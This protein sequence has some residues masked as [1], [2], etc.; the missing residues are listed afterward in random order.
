MP[1]ELALRWQAARRCAS[2]GVQL[3]GVPRSGR[4]ARSIQGLM[5]ADS[6]PWGVVYLSVPLDDWN[7]PAE[8]GALGLLLE[9][10]VD[11]APVVPQ[12]ALDLLVGALDRASA[13]ALVLGPGADTEEGFQ[14]A[15]ALAERARLPV[16]IAPS[17]PRAPFPTRHRCYQGQ[18]PSAAGAV[19][20]I[21]AQYDVVVCFGAPLFRYHAPSDQDFLQPG[22]SVYAVTDDPDEAARAPF[23]RICVGDPSDALVR[24]AATAAA[25]DRPWPPA[26]TLPEADTSG[27]PF[28]AEAILDAI[29][30]GKS[31]D[32]VIALEWTSADMVRDRLT[33]TRPKSL[34][35]PAAGGL[36]WGL[37]AAIGL[38]LGCPER[39]VVALIGD[40]AMQYTTSGLWSAVRYRVPVTFVVCTNTTYRAL[41]AFSE[42]LHVPEGDYLDISGL[43][44]LDIARGYGLDVHRA[45]SLED[46]T[47]YVRKG[48]TATGPRLVEILQ[49]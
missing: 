4:T 48:M 38:R 45:E 17:P 5:L 1:E 13:P 21:L 32:T 41:Q 27:P 39:P 43:G 6:A 24:V 34:F 25:S 19:A 42:I 9:R 11:G 7:E 23:G 10:A 35:Y 18:L 3:A 33:I 47:H 22:V 40:G 14:A 16:W 30:A 44:V 2:E 36:G 26:R 12:R 20:D 15:V 49:R 29:D 8:D 37:P 28:T 46:L 31:D